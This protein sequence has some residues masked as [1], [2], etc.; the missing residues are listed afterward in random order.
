MSDKPTAY[1]TTS[2]RYENAVKN[3]KNGEYPGVISYPNPDS[4]LGRI[5]NG[6]CVRFKA[7]SITEDNGEFYFETTDSGWRYMVIFT[8]LFD[9][10]YG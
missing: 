10:Y 9:Q 5:N 7:T 3:F 4:P 1:I 2:P 6:V 8:S